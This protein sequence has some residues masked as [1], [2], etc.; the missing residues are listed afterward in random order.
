LKAVS[1]KAFC[2]ILEGKGWE[3]NRINGSQ[4]IYAKDGESARISVS[5][6]GNTPLK[7]GLQRHFMKTT[8]IDESEL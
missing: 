5:V 2:R 8:G 1:G 3:L 7:P 4:R 6:H